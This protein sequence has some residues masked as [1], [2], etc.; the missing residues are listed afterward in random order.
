MRR[1]GVPLLALL[2]ARG[3]TVA[4]ALWAGTNPLHAASWVRW[5]SNIYLS[6]AQRGY[7]LEQ[8]GPASVYE[9]WQWCGN[10][11]W[12]PL[13]A[14]MLKIAS[15][16]LLSL[17][18]EAALLLVVWRFLL[19]E[20]SVPALL[21][22]AFF[23]G[24]IYQQA[25]F[26]VSLFLLCAA[27]FLA[28]CE[29]QRFAGAAGAGALAAM[30]YPS[31]FLL[32]PISLLKRNLWPAVGVTLG[33][34]LVLAVMRAQTGHWNAYFLA[35]QKYGF[36][37][38]PLDTL[39]SRLKP[40][41]NARYRSAMSFAAGAQTLLL[42]VMMALSVKQFRARPLIGAYCL[43]Y[44]AFPLCVGGHLSLYRAEALLV[45]LVV[46]L[47]L[48]ARIPLLAAAVPISFAM[49]VAFFRGTLV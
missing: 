39:F 6:I 1:F 32:A 15:G 47:P 26:P 33:F 11:G 46:L 21:L 23:P 35:Q 12:F 24:M 17:L 40:L 5:D 45:P 30:A 48:R 2:L 31:G 38:A 9:A 36:S 4:A 29:R 3:A 34:L 42:L 22:A 14:W 10:T 19:R 7:F 37:F 27:A 18:F 43:A 49:S 41:V 28:L 20:E 13:Y 25:V 8:C 16:A 44:W